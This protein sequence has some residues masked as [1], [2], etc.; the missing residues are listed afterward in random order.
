[1]QNKLLFFCVRLKV[2]QILCYILQ[3][4]KFQDIVRAE[5]YKCFQNGQ[6]FETLRH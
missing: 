2:S 6:Q 1:M 4:I 3:S 5:A